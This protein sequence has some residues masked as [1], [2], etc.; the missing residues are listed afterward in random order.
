MM[1]LKNRHYKRNIKALGARVLQRRLDYG[2][3]R[4]DVSRVSGLN[5][6]T[7]Y[8]FEAGKSIPKLETIELIIRTVENLHTEKLKVKG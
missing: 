4:T 2:V 7:I 5:T 3:E 6:S 8:R 1:T